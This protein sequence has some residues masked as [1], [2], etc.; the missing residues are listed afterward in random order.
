[1]NIKINKNIFNETF[2]P[3]LDDQTRLQIFFGGSSSGKSKFLSQRV[4]YDLLDGKRNYLVVRNVS[5]SLRASTFQE[6]VKVINE[7]NLE[8][9]F[10][11]NTSFMIITCLATNKQAL[12]KGL[13]DVSKIK[14]ITP[15]NGVITD[16]FIEEATEITFEAFKQLNKRLRG[17][18]QTTKRITLA[19]N[20]ILKNHW[21][22]KELFTKF[23]TDGNVYKDENKLILKTTYLDNSF[24]EQDDID[25]L[26]NEKDPY[27]YNVYTLGNWGMLGDVI[28]KNWKIESI[29]KELKDRFDCYKNGLDFGYSSD[30]FAFIRTHYDKKHK[31]I[32]VLHEVYQ[33]K[34]TNEEIAQIIRP[35][36]DR[37]YVTCDSAEPKSIKELQNLGIN[38]IPAKKGKDSILHGIQWLQ[39]HNI[40]VD[41][42]CQNMINEFQLYTWKSDKNNES[43]PIPI[44]RNNHLIDALR[45]TYEF[46]MNYT[47]LKMVKI[48]GI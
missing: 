40:I 41:P 5:H 43:L 13:D 45:Y 12:F 26:E 24:L 36:I 28:F 22:F 38:T 2:F 11:V 18:S 23:Y 44:D 37:E 47:T 30:P 31:T 33:K 15:A 20:P 21:I 1:M 29:S 4:V 27:W 8:K 3:Y 17:R 6:I 39:G 14:S 34:L 32:Y 16:I 48:K 19:F 42:V 25:E 10:K 46:E 7:W 9:Y 35:I